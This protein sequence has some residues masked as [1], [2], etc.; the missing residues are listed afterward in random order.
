MRKQR[1]DAL[2]GS[3]G[4]RRDGAYG[5]NSQEPGIPGAEWNVRQSSE[6]WRAV[7]LSSRVRREGRE[8]NCLKQPIR[9]PLAGDTEGEESI[10]RPLATAGSRSGA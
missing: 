6:G 9:S 4:V 5:K 8:R 10:T 1:V 7:A 3:P 2:V